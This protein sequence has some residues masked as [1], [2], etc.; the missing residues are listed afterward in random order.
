MTAAPTRRSAAQTRRYDLP[1][2]G[3]GVGLRSVHYGHILEHWP[4]VGW[5]EVLSENYMET[6]GRPRVILE[7]IAER[8]PVVS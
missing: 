2:L 1:N 5:F 8:Y 6:A 4:K 7:Q 3:I